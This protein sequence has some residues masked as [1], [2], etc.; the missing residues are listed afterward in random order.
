MTLH[1]NKNR[2]KSDDFQFKPPFSEE[3]KKNKRLKDDQKSLENNHSPRLRKGFSPGA[4]DAMRAMVNRDPNTSFQDA[5][6]GFDKKE[7]VQE[8]RRLVKDGKIAKK[9]AARR[10]NINERDAYMNNWL[11]RIERQERSKKEK[12]ERLEKIYQA[13]RY[14]EVLRT[15][16][17]LGGLN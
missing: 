6:S 16:G 5:A 2:R 14:I 11:A 15:T 10:V 12:R 1:P 7:A 4:S 13:E 8:A 3:E 9:T 17:A